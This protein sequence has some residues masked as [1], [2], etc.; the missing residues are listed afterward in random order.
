MH[1][2]LYICKELRNSIRKIKKLVEVKPQYFGLSLSLCTPNNAAFSQ[3][4]R[5]SRTRE[6]A[7]SPYIFRPP[8]RA[9]R[10]VAHTTGVRR[11]LSLYTAGCRHFTSTQKV[12]RKPRVLFSLFLLPL[13]AIP[14]SF[15]RRSLPPVQHTA[16]RF[17]P[18][19]LKFL[20]LF[21]RVCVLGL[22]AGSGGSRICAQAVAR[23]ETRRRI[24]KS[25]SCGACIVLRNKWNERGRGR[26]RVN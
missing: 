23:E 18:F 8:T 12:M 21:S 16:T 14:T 4:D 25:R 19:P 20:A 5:H 17:Q 10:A 11:R 6:R 13:I 15:A 7:R 24:K 2:I 26:E 3:R 1:V 22:N 9:Q